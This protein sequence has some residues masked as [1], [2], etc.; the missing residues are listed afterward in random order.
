MYV[1]DLRRSR[2]QSV[3]RHFPRTERCE[4]M[5]ASPVVI[6]RS[7]KRTLSRVGLL[8]MRKFWL[9]VSSLE[10]VREEL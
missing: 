3:K 4:K 7:E 8:E 9:I 6:A 5:S 1:A 2:Y 10:N